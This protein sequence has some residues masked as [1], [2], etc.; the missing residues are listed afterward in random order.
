[1]VHELGKAMVYTFSYGDWIA[2]GSK[3]KPQQTELALSL[4]ESVDDE[5]VR[6][7]LETLQHKEAFYEV[8]AQFS[9]RPFFVLTATC[10]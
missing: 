6:T 3:A 1:M 5:G 7:V 10:P 8:L 4:I 9:C 2:K